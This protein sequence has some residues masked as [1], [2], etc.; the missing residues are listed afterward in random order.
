MEATGVVGPLVLPGWTACAGCLAQQRTARDPTWPRLWAQWH[1]GRQRQVIAGDMTLASTVSSL[2]AAH[3]LSFLDGELPASAG[4][5][6]EVSAPHFD[7]KTDRLEPYPR[8]VCGAD[9]PAAYQANA[10]R[11]AL[12]GHAADRSGSP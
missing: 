6:C 4:A 5:R 1:S 12:E 9:R 7:W 2:A 10:E 11:Q 3:A 8:C